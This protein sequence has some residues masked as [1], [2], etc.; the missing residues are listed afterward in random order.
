MFY[1]LNRDCKK[2]YW[3]IQDHVLL[4]RYDYFYPLF[5]ISIEHS[6]ICSQAPHVTVNF[7]LMQITCSQ[8]TFFLNGS[9]KLISWYLLNNTNLAGAIRF[10]FDPVTINLSLYDAD[11]ILQ[12]R[13][14]SVTR[15][16]AN[17]IFPWGLSMYCLFGLF[18]IHWENKFLI[19]FVYSGSCIVW[20]SIYSG[21]KGSSTFVQVLQFY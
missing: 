20:P 21:N 3:L 4:T 15:S 9:L 2:S 6:F 19:I 11:T 10:L 1:P 7:W 12:Y 18:I 14:S 8:N 5:H 13:K 17:N 16:A